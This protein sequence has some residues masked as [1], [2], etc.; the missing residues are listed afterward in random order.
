[1]N[2]HRLQQVLAV[3][4]FSGVVAAGAA[5]P[6]SAAPSANP[7]API[8]AAVASVSDGGSTASAKLP[9][10]AL[11]A[12]RNAGLP[13]YEAGEVEVVYASKM[14]AYYGTEYRRVYEVDALTS[15][16][17]KF[18]AVGAVAPDHF[19]V[20]SG[21]KRSDIVVNMRPAANQIF[22]RMTYDTTPQKWLNSPLVQLQ[23][24]GPSIG[25]ALIR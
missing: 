21:D 7:L 1:M 5:V 3:T 13:I 23:D 15:P 22:Q 6:A 17:T 12:A 8:T 20:V 19:Y 9:V 24:G 14:G 10:D 11:V 4:A 16:T 25:I 2:T 18:V